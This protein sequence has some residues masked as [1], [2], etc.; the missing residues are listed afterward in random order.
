MRRDRSWLAVSDPSAVDMVITNKAKDNRVT[1][2]IQVP[3]TWSDG[4]QEQLD[5]LVAKV[6]GY[7]G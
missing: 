6:N 5:Q 2:V 3:L 1:L 4:G 7:L